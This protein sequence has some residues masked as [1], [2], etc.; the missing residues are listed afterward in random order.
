MVG[1]NARGMGS[2]R[3][4]KRLL[5][6]GGG[7]VRQVSVTACVDV[8]FIWRGMALPEETRECSCAF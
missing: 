7:T 4:I 2:W 1:Y 5:T 8:R 6:R 3:T